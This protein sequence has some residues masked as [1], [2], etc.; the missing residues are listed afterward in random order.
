MLRVFAPICQDRLNNAS[1]GSH[2]N[3]DMASLCGAPAHAYRYPPEGTWFYR[4]SATGGGVADSPV[5]RLAVPGELRLTLPL[6]GTDGTDLSGVLITPEGRRTA[7]EARMQDG[8]A[9]GEGRLNDRAV[10]FDGKSA[11]LK[12][13]PKWHGP[14]TC[15]CRPIRWETRW[16]SW[17]ATGR[18]RPSTAAFRACRFRRAR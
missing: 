2:A 17:D 10:A 7:I 9:W 6:N 13:P 4:I 11:G 15:C 1:L 18:I 14:T 16:P 3:W 8:A 12:L 5:V